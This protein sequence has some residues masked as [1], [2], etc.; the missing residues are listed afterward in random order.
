MEKLA[1][2]K[3]G[4]FGWLRRAQRPV[5]PDASAE[6]LGAQALPPDRS[7][8]AP[9]VATV[10]WDFT[11]TALEIRNFAVLSTAPVVMVPAERMLLYTL[12]YATQ[13]RRYLEIGTLQG[14]SAAIV[15]GALD[16]LGIPTPMVLVDP[17]PAIDPE[18][19]SN[20]AHRATLLRGFSPAVLPDAV[21]AGGGGPFDFVLVDGDHTKAGVL[22]DL[23]GVLPLCAVGAYIL[24]HDCFFPEIAAA[25]DEFVLAAGERVADL[26]PLTRVTAP[27][28]IDAEPDPDA[29]KWA[30]FRLLQVRQGN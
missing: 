30:G 4:G 6:T 21:V 8:L 14:G 3:E 28:A 10:D 16:S 26:G 7:R 5:A 2:N 13:P 15:C 19:W 18:L 27:S 24:C 11:L 17:A 25:I 20:L 22:A 1:A 29:P 9:P 12:V 23:W